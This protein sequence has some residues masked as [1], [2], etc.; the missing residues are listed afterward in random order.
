M[1][2]TVQQA[3]SRGR[4]EGGTFLLFLSFVLVF[5]QIVQTSVMERCGKRPMLATLP[6][7]MPESEDADWTL[8]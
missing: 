6:N 8:S 4:E 3:Q 5:G 7:P 2:H 1:E